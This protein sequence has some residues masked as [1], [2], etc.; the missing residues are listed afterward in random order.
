VIDFHSH[1]LP[2]VDDGAKDVETAAKMLVLSKSQGV[3]TVVATPHFYPSKMSVDDFLRNRQ[4]SYLKLKQ[5]IED[6]N[7]NVP[8]IRLGAEVAFSHE[9]MSM[10]PER[11]RIEGTDT[12]LIELPFTFWN[13]W[14]YDDLFELSG[15]YKLNVVIAH[16]ER[17]IENVKAF[18]FIQSLFDLN[19]FI[20]VNATS[21]IDKS[22]RKIIK[23]LFKKCRIDLLGTDMHNLGERTSNIDS[24]VRI[25]SKK[26]GEECIADILSNSKELLKLG[27][28]L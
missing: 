24:A 20:Q 27:R 5:Y 16:L 6:N 19:V 18:K 12:I 17:Y 26:Y 14:V 9:F 1:V 28:I 15:R 25:I 13:N 4:E 11:L 7:L 8:E 22:K 21:I 3:D 23:H 10:N 2:F